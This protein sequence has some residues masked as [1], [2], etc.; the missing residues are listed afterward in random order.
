M[1]I[2]SVTSKKSEQ[3]TLCKRCSDY[4]R[5]L[6]S[7]YCLN[8]INL[9]EQEEEEENKK[10]HPEKY[11]HNFPKRFIEWDKERLLPHYQKLLDCN[12][13]SQGLYLEG[14]QGSGKTCFITVLG[15]EF[16][17]KFKE[18]IWFVNAV[19]LMYEVKGTFDKESKFFNDYDVIMKYAKKPVLVI[20]DLGSEKASEYVRQSFYALIN[21]RYLEDLKTF[22][23]S[24]YS[25]EHLAS[26]Y[27]ASI[28]S[29]IAEM[30]ENVDMGNTD[31]RL[32]RRTG[33]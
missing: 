11:M 25:L 9:I 21:H 15:K 18:D 24:F 29:R 12:I 5:Y 26:R 2:D 14:I 4:P 27:D 23:T 7:L 19:S 13:E 3:P 6:N 16:V 8:C 33:K 1:G 31:L 32:Q 22:I 10:L 17:R 28:A 30:C 20:D